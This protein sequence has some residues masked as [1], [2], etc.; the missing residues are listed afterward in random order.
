LLPA[1]LSSRK[2]HEEEHADASEQDDETANPAHALDSIARV[3]TGSG[4]GA[5]AHRQRQIKERLH[6][7]PT[8]RGL[9]PKD[10]GCYV[11]TSLVGT[12]LSTATS[13]ASSRVR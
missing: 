9:E 10:G 12:P 5:E 7:G 6:V 2:H 3:Q 1:L 11:F 4:L 8:W 13:H